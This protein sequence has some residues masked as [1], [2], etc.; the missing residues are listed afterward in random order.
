MKLFFLFM[1]IPILEIIVFLKVNEVIGF[2]F[3]I[4]SIIATAFIGT[5]LVKRQGK[6]II[7]RLKTEGTNLILLLSNGVLILIAGV[8][9]LTPGFVTDTLG[10]L[11]LVPPIRQ[12]TITYLSKKLITT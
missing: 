1:T 10:F 4:S 5:L 7:L 2:V 12:R 9:L 3:T 6:D 8:F 11:I